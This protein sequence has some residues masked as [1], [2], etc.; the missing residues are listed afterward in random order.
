MLKD[1]DIVE[2]YDNENNK[3]CLKNQ[4]KKVKTF[5]SYNLN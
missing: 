5:L 4:K 1:V 2:I 3:A